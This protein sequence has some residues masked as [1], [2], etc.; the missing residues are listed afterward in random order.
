MLIAYFFLESDKILF[1][2]FGTGEKNAPLVKVW[3]HSTSFPNFRKLFDCYN[4]SAIHAGK[5]HLAS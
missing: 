1:S 2:S 4:E 5:A 3:I